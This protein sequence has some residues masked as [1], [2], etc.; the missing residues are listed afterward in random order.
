MPSAR[1][2]VSAIQRQIL[3][4]WETFGRRRVAVGR[5]RHNMEETTGSFQHI[6]VF[7]F[8]K[9]VAQTFLSV[10]H[11]RHAQ[12]RMSVP[13]WKRFPAKR[14]SWSMTLLRK[15]RRSA[16]CRRACGISDGA[17]PPSKGRWIEDRL[18]RAADRRL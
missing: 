4:G 1:P 15:T 6:S 12:T 14:S 2:K 10:L 16:D 8:H 18:D 5:L 11:G 7:R 13:P 17:P 3:Q 9:K